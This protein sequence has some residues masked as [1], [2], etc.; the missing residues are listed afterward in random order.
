MDEMTARRFVDLGRVADGA[1][2]MCG[3][4]IARGFGRYWVDGV[5]VV[6]GVR[7][8]RVRGRW[9]VPAGDV[10]VWRRRATYNR[11]AEVQS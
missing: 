7:E 1:V 9:L 6:D 11:R 4:M 5:R 10:S 3:D 2:P 8:L